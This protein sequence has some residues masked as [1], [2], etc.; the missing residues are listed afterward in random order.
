M[1]TTVCVTEPR[2]DSRLHG[3]EVGREPSNRQGRARGHSTYTNVPTS[4]SLRCNSW[5]YDGRHMACPAPRTR[6]SSHLLVHRPCL[7]APVRGLFLSRSCCRSR[8]EWGLPVSRPVDRVVDN[9]ID[10]WSAP[11]R[12]PPKL[13]WR[14]LERPGHARSCSSS[15]W[16]DVP[17]S[18]CGTADGLRRERCGSASVCSDPVRG[19]L[20]SGRRG[21]APFGAPP[22]AGARCSVSTASPGMRRRRRRRPQRRHANIRRVRLARRLLRAGRPVDS[23]WRGHVVLPAWPA[24]SLARCADCR[25]RRTSGDRRPADA[26]L[27]ACS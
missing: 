10:C 16:V 4:V 27:R 23:D 26:G 14:S 6:L 3:V 9:R 20:P 13:P 5:L 19:N 17:H 1:P 24:G 18:L 25:R 21:V 11:W 7:H 12:C 22:G 2:R 15:A 8:R